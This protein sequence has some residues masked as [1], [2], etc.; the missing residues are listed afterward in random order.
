MRFALWFM[1]IVSV[2]IAAILV[3]TFAASGYFPSAI[4]AV[5]AV[6]CAVWAYTLIKELPA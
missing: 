3:F 2:L 6:G 4:V 1:C 5:W